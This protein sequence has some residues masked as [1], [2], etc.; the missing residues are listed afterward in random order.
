MGRP[1]NCRHCGH[2]CYIGDG[3]G[4]CDER[5]ETMSKG[6]ITASRNCSKLLWCHIDAVTGE[7]Y[8]EQAAK[9]TVDDGQMSLEV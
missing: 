7:E 2:L 8:E 9:K 6:Q 3:F 5:K 1:R 4:Y